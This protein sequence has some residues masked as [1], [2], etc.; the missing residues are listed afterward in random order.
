[1]MDA[2]F[3]LILSACP[4][5]GIDPGNK[6]SA[7]LEVLVWKAMYKRLASH[8]EQMQAA[9]E[10]ILLG[11]YNPAVEHYQ[12]ELDVAFLTDH[13]LSRRPFDLL[14]FL[15]ANQQLRAC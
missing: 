15:R 14:E 8:V 4:L 7:E 13:F 9:Y 10:R 11:E 3:D 2:T 1:M 12:F 6:T 5:L